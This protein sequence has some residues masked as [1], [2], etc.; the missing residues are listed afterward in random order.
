L[1]RFVREPIN[2][3]T[4]L[5]GAVL[6]FAGLLML[7]IKASLVTKSAL[8]ITAVTIFGISMIL[9]YSASATFH[10][11]IA[12]RKVIRFL[13]KMDHSMIFLLIFGT[14]TPF[15]LITLNGWIG[16]T[17][18]GIVTGCAVAGILFK[19]IWFKSPKWVS[20]GLYLAMGWLII[21]AFVPLATNMATGGVVFLVVGGVS[22]TLGGIIYGL[23]PAWMKT[24]FLGFHEI[25]HLFVLF[26]SFS[27]FY[28][29]FNYVL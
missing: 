4:H 11:V 6:A 8:A 25:F 17:V 18:W 24:K 19:F 26:G 14:Y 9:L 5:A 22:Y 15:C 28:S 16:W 3:F 1:K 2:G 7:V 27:H 21:I 13:Q 12:S 29:I 20:T 10:M 23:E